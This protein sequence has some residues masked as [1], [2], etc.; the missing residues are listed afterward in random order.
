MLLWALG[1]VVNVRDRADRNAEHAVGRR[2]DA[3]RLQLPG[4]ARIVQQRRR[5]VVAGADDKRNLVSLLQVVELFRKFREF[6]ERTDLIRPERQIPDLIGVGVLLQGSLERSK[7]L[8][9]EQR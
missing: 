3:P 7:E 2:G 1:L 5:V 8:L 9:L 4:C 6:V